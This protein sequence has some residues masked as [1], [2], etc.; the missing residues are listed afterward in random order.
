[1]KP[2]RKHQLVKRWLPE[3]QPAQGLR[4]DGRLVP[5]PLQ[6]DPG[7][8]PVL[9]DELNSGS[10]NDNGNLQLFFPLGG[11]RSRTTVLRSLP[12]H[13]LLLSGCS[14]QRENHTQL[15]HTR[16]LLRRLLVKT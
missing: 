7:S 8:P 3:G 9:P 10:P 14:R 4:T 12:F 13:P 16:L 11:K 6:G 15:D 1:M 5:E 2:G